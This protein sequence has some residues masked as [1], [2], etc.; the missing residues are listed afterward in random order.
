MDDL[1]RPVT[2][3][4]SEPYD[5]AL[6]LCCLRSIRLAGLRKPSEGLELVCHQCDDTIVFNLGKWMRLIDVEIQP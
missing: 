3:D 4:F 5:L 6:H 2:E 1:K